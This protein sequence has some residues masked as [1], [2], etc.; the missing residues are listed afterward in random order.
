MINSK[1]F[2]HEKS[3]IE[4][5]AVIGPGT[6][7]WSFTHILGGARIG[8]DC[9]I[10]D[11]VFIENLVKIGNRVTIKS[12]VQLWDGVTIENNVFVGPNVTFTNDKFPRSKSYIEKY[13][14][15]VIKNNA[16]IGANSTILPG[17]NIGEYSMIGAGAVVTMDV[18]KYAIVA[19]NP[20]KII[21]YAKDYPETVNLNE[22]RATNDDQI[23]VT[24]VQ[25]IN[26]KYVN[27]MRGNLTETQFDRDLPFLLKRIFIIDSVPDAK[28]RG[29]HAHLHCHQCLVCVKGSVS[30]SV[31][32][33]Y[34]RQE[35]EL[36]SPKIGLYMPPLIWG[37]QYNYS[38]DA[39]LMVYASHEYDESDYIRDY[40]LFLTEVKNEK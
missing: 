2:I 30:V 36:S 25:L 13:P 31:D 24:G 32:N 19:G 17:L 23:K 35:I 37:A 1:A 12:G 26:F 27:D 21:G 16:S 15:T 28:V 33:G 11:Y 34:V 18:P 38:R 40:N 20:A 22:S 5:G 6:K 7:V 10:C 29:E 14:E 39:V 9:N 4:P 3:I 8:A